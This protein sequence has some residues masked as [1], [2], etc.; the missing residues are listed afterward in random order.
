MFTRELDLVVPVCRETSTLATGTTLAARWLHGPQPTSDK[1][2]GVGFPHRVVRYRHDGSLF[3]ST[4]CW[5]CIL[6]GG[7]LTRGLFLNLP[8]SG[9]TSTLTREATLAAHWLYDPQAVGNQ[10]PP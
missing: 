3:L 2:L 7:F 6:L 5:G 9:E 1:S 4:G 8:G 10:S